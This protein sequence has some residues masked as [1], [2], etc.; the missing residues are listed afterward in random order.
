MGRDAQGAQF[1]LQVLKLGVELL[2]LLVKVH[3]DIVDVT[4][5]TSSRL[6]STPLLF[7][8]LAQALLVPIRLRVEGVVVGSVFCIAKHFVVFVA[9]R[10]DSRRAR[11][12]RGLV[13]QVLITAALSRDPTCCFDLLLD[14]AGTA[15]QVFVVA[16]VVTFGVVRLA[17]SCQTVGVSVVGLLGQLLKFSLFFAVG[18]RSS[19]APRTN[20][21]SRSIPLLP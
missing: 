9:G 18:D 15:N 5:I 2:F 7:L 14:P 4:A 8:K 19:L 1:V 20:V 13:S 11:P 10:R 17:A 16:G 12:S 6:V 3:E 21:T